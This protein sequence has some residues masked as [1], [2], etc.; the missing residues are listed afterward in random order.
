MSGCHQPACWLILFDRK[1]KC[2][3]LRLSTILPTH[4]PPLCQ[5]NH[6]KP[7]AAFGLAASGLV[8]S[9]LASFD[10]WVFSL[11][12]LIDGCGFGGGWFHGFATVGCVASGFAVVGLAAVVLRS[13]VWWH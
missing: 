8:A 13:W 12:L 5:P 3:R 2:G 1:K 4:C 9:G 6:D 7:L 10:Q 11:A